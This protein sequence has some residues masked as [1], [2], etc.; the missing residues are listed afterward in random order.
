MSNCLI[1]VIGRWLKRGGYVIARKSHWGWWLHFLWSPD[2]QTFEEF[3]PGR[4]RRRWLPPVLFRGRV[5]K[6][7]P[8]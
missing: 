6:F 7:K 4:Y 8:K 3:V 5:K 1:F 2:L